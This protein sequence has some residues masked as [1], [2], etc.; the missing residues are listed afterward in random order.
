VPA[1]SSKS[2]PLTSSY[3][4]TLCRV[5]G[6]ISDGSSDVFIWVPGHVGLTGNSAADGAAKA[7]LIRPVS[8]L[9]VPHSD[10]KSLIR[11]QA[12]RQWQP[13]RNSETEN[14]LYSIETRMNVINMLRLPRRDEITIH[15]L[16]I[17]HTYLT[18]GHLFRG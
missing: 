2:R 15:R 14:K 6:L 5:H 4:E 8:G 18:H 3:A 13:R 11:I 9:T 7:A 17:E 16:R 1:K 12:L 10:F